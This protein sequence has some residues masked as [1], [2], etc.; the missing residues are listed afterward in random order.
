MIFPSSTC[1][2]LH[3]PGPLKIVHTS[4]AELLFV[5]NITNYICGA[6]IVMWRN[7]GKFGKFWRT[8]GKFWNIFI[9]FG[10]F[11]HNLRASMWRKIEPKKFICGEKMS[12]MRSAPRSRYALKKRGS[13]LTESRT[14][15]SKI[16]A[17]YP[18]ATC[19]SWWSAWQALEDNHR[20]RGGRRGARWTPV[21]CDLE[22]YGATGNKKGYLQSNANFV[23]KY[24]DLYWKRHLVLSTSNESC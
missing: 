14:P 9:N 10:R 6:K 7:F 12:N 8:I 23:M 1:P 15:L 4:Q 3:N 22:N 17:Q 24:F 2:H 19:G 21:T 13:F 5:T 20:W 18:T 16:V 11:C